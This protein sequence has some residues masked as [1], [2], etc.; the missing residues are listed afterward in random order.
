MARQQ[1][2][3]RVK[4]T[5]Y[6][7]GAILA[8]GLTGFG[9]LEVINRA[10]KRAEMA[11]HI[12][13]QTVVVATRDLYMGI[14]ISG[15][16]VEEKEILP[17]EIQAEFGYDSLDNV[18]HKTPRERIYKGEV[19]RFER[20]A[21]ETEGKGLNAIIERGK[22]AMTIQTDAQSSLSGMLAPGNHVD[23]IVTIRPDDRSLGASWVTET[24]LEDVK[25]LAVG[26][27]LV[28]RSTTAESKKKSRRREKPSVTLQVTPSEAEKLALASSKGDLHLVLRSEVDDYVA[29]DDGS[30]LDTNTLLGM[31][32][33]QPAA[34]S[35]GGG[36][37][38]KT[39][40]AEVIQGTQS[41][42]V[43][44]DASGQTIVGTESGGGR[45][46]R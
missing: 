37:K 18:M 13:K 42:T 5:I 15:E 46:R 19:V 41:T 12:E 36:A 1:T 45:R 6:L 22:R 14:P 32:K 27:S 40:R 7:G 3:G 31:K 2:G 21:D 16:D 11:G 38:P 23:V 26:D 43:G 34:R 24:I 35:G 17:D 29:D 20:L 25:V 4:A 30:V 10:N 28:S 9:M 44:F 39:Q 8:A 33:K